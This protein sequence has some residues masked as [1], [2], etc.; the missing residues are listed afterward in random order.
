MQLRPYIKRGLHH[1]ASAMAL[2]GQGAR[3]V[4]TCL[5]QAGA[6][7]Y[8]QDFPLI[9]YL[10]KYLLAALL[11]L[12]VALKM[13]M[14]QPATA[15][16]TVIIV[17]HFRSGMVITKSYYR[18]LGT[19]VG[20]LFSML[21]V[22]WFSQDRFPFFIAAALWIGLCTAGS[23]AYRNFQSYGFVLAGYT[24]CIVGLP[25][26]QAPWHTFQIASTR[27]SEIGV[28][29]LSA[30]LV[31]ELILPQRL[32]ENIL[33][34]VRGKFRDFCELLGSGAP[35]GLNQPFLTVM[36][37]FYQ[38]ESFRS[39]VQ[40][41][42][43][44]ARLHSTTINRLNV[45]FMAVSTG[46]VMF[47]R[48]VQRLQA[49][50]RTAEATAL[51]ALMQPLAAAILIDGRCAGNAQ[52]LVTV[53][54]AV[55][56]FQQHFDTAFRQQQQ[57]L[58]T[59]PDLD[60][61][62]MEA[63]AELLQR[64]AAALSGYL[65]T[66]GTL[67]A[68]ARPQQVE[69][70]EFAAEQLYL[71]IDWLP[72]SIAALRGALTLLIIAGMWMAVDWPSGILAMTM[73]VVTNTLF[74]ASPAPAATIR[75]F[76]FGALLGIVLMY[77]SNVFWLTAAHDYVMLCIVISP[78]IL[79]TAWL[80]AR[81]ST[82]L[83]GAGLGIAY[84]LMAGFNQSLGDNPAQYFNDSIALVI[85]L[86][87]SGMMFSLTDYAASPWAKRRLFVQLRRLV[88]DACQGQTMTAAEFEMRARDLIQRSGHAH[89]PQDADSVRVVEA[90]CAT[91]EIGQ[92]V[93]ALR[94]A[95]GGLPEGPQKWVQHTL[96]LVMHYYRQP[97][98]K[99]RQQVL[100]WLDYFLTWL[101]EGD[102]AHV[103]PHPLPA[104]QAGKLTT[105]LHFIRLVIQ[106][107]APVSQHRPVA[108]EIVHAT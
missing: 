24:L 63:G 7:W 95:A 66:Y 58:V 99:N 79:L 71:H 101:Q 19:V 21:L 39:S 102:E 13:E 106:A 73:G 89:R 3:L 5:Q 94:A 47:Q 1:L 90:L 29:L 55:S 92:A 80:S 62:E 96:A 51:L 70:R 61:L 108:K 14:D 84:F 10:F 74:A 54:Q 77:V 56:A 49:G 87:V 107:G 97:V 76:S 9:G 37:D 91:L 33:A 67:L 26:T 43:D 22:A 52:E 30:T 38:L 72:V 50:G 45:Q 15:L 75:Q 18:L 81:P 103:F 31:S 28:G 83:V 41:E 4:I 64:L 60:W 17:M 23:L 85:A 2:L 86:A 11:A 32:W 78:V 100:R 69:T 104:G 16:L 46:Y 20:I 34:M 93:I 44:D 42:T 82:T 65:D 57:A 40:F 88:G 35:T 8:R 6:E 98:P 12:W 25:A 48:L 105:Q 59:A 68:R 27:L 53:Q 36:Q